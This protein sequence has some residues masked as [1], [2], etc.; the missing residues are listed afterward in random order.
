MVVREFPASGVLAYLNPLNYRANA[1]PPARSVSGC[2]GDERGLA[3]KLSRA[4]SSLMFPTD[5]P[6]ARSTTPTAPWW[7]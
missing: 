3:V 1:Q 6:F 4:L 2:G 7:R 5:R